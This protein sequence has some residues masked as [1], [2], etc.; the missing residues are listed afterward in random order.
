MHYTLELRATTQK[1]SLYISTFSHNCETNDYCYLQLDIYIITTVGHRI[2]VIY[3]IDNTH[4]HNRGT[5]DYCFTQMTNTAFRPLRCISPEHSS[6]QVLPRSHQLLRKVSAEFVDRFS[7]VVCFAKEKSPLD[8]GP[9]TTESV[10]ARQRPPPLLIIARILYW[11]AAVAARR[12]CITLWTWSRIVP[13]D[14]RRIREADRLCLKVP[15]RDRTPLFA[16]GQRSTCHHFCG[17]Q[18]SSVFTGSSFH[19]VIR[20][21]TTLVSTITRQACTAYGFSTPSTMG[22]STQRI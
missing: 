18:V 4:S 14:G 15:D 22:T 10:S 17:D 13:Y 16:T 9:I 7:T 19:I 3:N 12:R 6:A 1:V 20:P 5:C 2:I 21:Q 11:T 8:V